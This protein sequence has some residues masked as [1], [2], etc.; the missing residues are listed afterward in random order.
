MEQ[1]RCSHLLLFIIVCG[2]VLINNRSY[3]C[4]QQ[5]GGV[6][7]LLL[8]VTLISLLILVL[9]SCISQCRAA[10]VMVSCLTPVIPVCS[11]QRSGAVECSPILV[12]VD[13]RSYTSVRDSLVV[14]SSCCFRLLVLAQVFN[15]TPPVHSEVFSSIVDM[16]PGGAFSGYLPYCCLPL[17]GSI[18]LISCCV[19]WCQFT[20]GSVGTVLALLAFGHGPLIETRRGSNSKIHSCGSAGIGCLLIV[21]QSFSRHAAAY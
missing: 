1:R 16:M 5:L 10:N 19:S 14:S 17:V 20:V 11:L 13:N 21:V 2:G 3:Q 7:V 8:L 15:M 6:V 9:F 12:G 4:P 18:I